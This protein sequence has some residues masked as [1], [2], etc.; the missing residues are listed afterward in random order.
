MAKTRI[1]K[2]KGSN[3]I[4]LPRDQRPKSMPVGKRMPSVVSAK[5][6]K[7]KGDVKI[8]FLLDKPKK[9]IAKDRKKRGGERNNRQNGCKIRCSKKK[10]TLLIQLV[11]NHDC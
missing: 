10:Q 3:T 7:S 6:A 4:T 9:V 5:K 8:K 11:S 1:T 2:R